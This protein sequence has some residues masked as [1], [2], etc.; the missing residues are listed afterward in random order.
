MD[1][2]HE[3]NASQIKLLTDEKMEFKKQIEEQ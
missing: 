1:S 3:Q 2:K